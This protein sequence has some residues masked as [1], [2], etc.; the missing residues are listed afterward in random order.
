MKTEKLDESPRSLKKISHLRIF[1]VTKARGKYLC[2]CGAVVDCYDMPLAI[3][4]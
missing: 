2:V 1:A 4:P 3:D